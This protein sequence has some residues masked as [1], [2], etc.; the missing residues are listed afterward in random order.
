MEDLEEEEDLGTDHLDIREHVNLVTAE[1]GN[2][3]IVL[4]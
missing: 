4:R 3:N 2:N 1:W